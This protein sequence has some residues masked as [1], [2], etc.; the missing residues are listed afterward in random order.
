MLC[1]VVQIVI[2]ETLQLYVLWWCNLR[3]QE[4]DIIAARCSV[5]LSTSYEVYSDSFL[6][7]FLIQQASVVANDVYPTKGFCSFL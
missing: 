6:P 2:H 5:L 3:V 7:H 4:I 1:A